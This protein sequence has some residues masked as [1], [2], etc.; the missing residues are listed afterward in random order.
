MAIKIKRLIAILLFNS[1]SVYVLF[2][3]SA[4]LA[5]E[6]SCFRFNLLIFSL[7]FTFW[8]ARVNIQKCWCEFFHKIAV[9]LN[10]SNRTHRTKQGISFCFPKSV[11]LMHE[12]FRKSILPAQETF[13][14]RH[15]V[16]VSIRTNQFTIRII[17]SLNGCWYSIIF[18]FWAHTFTHSL[19]TR[20]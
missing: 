2:V 3:F 19:Q 15:G 16:H 17:W 11:E 7:C 6:H 20:R 9:E 4:A 12:N 8:S 13:Y 10:F 5:L 18:L 1:L 14:S